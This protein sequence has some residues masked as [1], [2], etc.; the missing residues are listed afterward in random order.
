MD[1]CKVYIVDST[2]PSNFTVSAEGDFFKLFYQDYHG[3]FSHVPFV[4]HEYTDYWERGV[5]VIHVTNNYKER[6]GR[7]I[8]IPGKNLTVFLPNT[9][10]R[11]N[12]SELLNQL[13]E[14]NSSSNGER[15]YTNLIYVKEKTDFGYNYECYP[16]QYT[17][18]SKFPFQEAVK[19]FLRD[20]F[21]ELTE[22]EAIM[23]DEFRTFKM[24]TMLSS[25]DNLYYYPVNHN[26]CGVLVVDGEGQ[27]YASTVTKTGHQEVL[28]H[29]LLGMTG[30]YV[31]EEELTLIQEV[32]DLS[33]A[34]LFFRE[35]DVYSYIPEKIEELQYNELLTVIE[36]IDINSNG[37]TNVSSARVHSEGSL[38]DEEL[39]FQE[40]ISNSYLEFQKGKK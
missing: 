20:S 30:R 36:Q 17:K 31:W 7:V 22:D 1:V 21:Y 13:E 35:G 2:S 27:S 37:F 15:Y 8:E 3:V 4:H 38:V 26:Y 6:D 34:V 9:V 39:S 23:F 32:T 5:P 25:D 19:L 40:N 11:E 14:I 12:A 33:L 29:L 24:R 10:S 18:G 16:P 28:N